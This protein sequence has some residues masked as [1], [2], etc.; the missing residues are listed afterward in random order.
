MCLDDELWHLQQVRGPVVEPEFVQ[1]FAKSSAI[2]AP[3]SPK[4]FHK[5]LSDEVQV[6]ERIIKEAGIKI[7]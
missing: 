2:P 3:M 6:V 7:E 5:V 4:E 1:L